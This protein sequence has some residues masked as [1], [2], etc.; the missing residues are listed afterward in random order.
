[1]SSG[2]IWLY[3][4]C[5]CNLRCKYCYQAHRTE[6]MTPSTSKAT[7]DW[8]ID[9]L[10]REKI[11]NG[12]IF[13]YGGEPLLNYKNLRYIVEYSQNLVRKT[14]K[15]IYYYLVTNGTLLT[16]KMI[17]FLDQFDVSIQISVD[18]PSHIHNITR[19]TVD[20][21]GS[22]DKIG[23]RI[24]LKKIGGQSS[25]Y[26]SA[27]VCPDTVQSLCE[28]MGFLVEQG[29][30]GIQFNVALENKQIWSND[31][32]NI[33]RK[34][35]RKIIDLCKIQIQDDKIVFENEIQP[36][37]DMIRF[38]Y[39]KLSKQLQHNKLLESES[40]IKCSAGRSNYSID[41][42][43]NIYPC[44]RIIDDIA[45]SDAAKYYL[46]NVHIGVWKYEALE[47]FR[48]FLPRKKMGIRCHSCTWKYIC[49]F[50]CFGLFKGSNKDDLNPTEDIC[51]LTNIMGEEALSYIEG[52]KLHSARNRSEE[53][54]AY[55]AE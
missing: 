22:F 35:V 34:E 51:A 49:S 23:G 24:P 9:M 6:M 44:S 38:V 47:E 42:N 37:A 29:F 13:F 48:S 53:V 25:R 32:R 27:V 55:V 40:T 18:G 15:K 50:Q 43:G 2:C 36:V 21:K 17:E 3:L 41:Y 30:R 31:Y 54:G 11:D 46:G 26:A 33:F 1:M 16:D 19:K 10:G 28:S 12:T 20:G 5:G 7:V 4:A 39:A 52:L 14:N 8:F 45:V